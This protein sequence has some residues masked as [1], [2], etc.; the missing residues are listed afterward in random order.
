MT[1][2]V[3]VVMGVSG[4]G[5]S[6]VGLQL[7]QRLGWSFKEGDDLHPAANLAKMQGGE[8]LTDSDRAPWLAAVA[9]WIDAWRLEGVRGVITCSA[10]KRSY[11]RFLTDRR[12]RLAFVFLEGKEAVL[13]A[14]LAKRRG[15]FM[16][17]SLLAS[18]FATLEPPGADEPVMSVEIDQPIAAQVDA[19]AA[20]MTGGRPVSRAGSS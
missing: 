14:R 3:V 19:I 13:A 15:H 9:A 16:P 10:L 5:K 12:P 8:P 7:A 1:P 6:T 17:L 20:M 18:Q 2:T 4:S 11:R